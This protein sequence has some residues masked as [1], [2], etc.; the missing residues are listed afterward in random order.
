[1]PKVVRVSNYDD[2]GPE[3]DQYV[4]PYLDVEVLSE[5]EAEE[6]AEALNSD[7]KRSDRDFF[8]V[9]PDDYVPWKFHE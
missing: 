5:G 7:S 4:V 9:K 6:W 3:G 1:M 8:V 2:E